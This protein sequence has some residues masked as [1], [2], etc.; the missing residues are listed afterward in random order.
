[1]RES[2]SIPKKI[3]EGDFFMSKNW[4]KFEEIIFKTEQ[5]ANMAQALHSAKL[6]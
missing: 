6:H 4:L 5:L 3:G 1:M 2:L